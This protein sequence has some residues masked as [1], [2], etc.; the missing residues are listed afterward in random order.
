MLNDR[1]ALITGGASGLGLAVAKR[2]LAAGASVGI[3]DRSA[4][5]LE[6]ARAELG[7]RVVTTHGDVTSYDDNRRAVG[8][9]V[10]AFG[11]LDVFVG[12]AGIFDNYATLDEIPAEKLGAAF[13]ELFGIDVKGYILGAKA[14][15]AE[16]RKNKGAIVFTASIS[17]FRPGYGGLLYITAKHA[18]L[19][20]TRR[21]ALELAPDV[22]V[23][24]VAPGYVPTNLA[25]TS[26]LGQTPKAPGTKP[27]LARFPLGFYPEIDDFT[28]LYLMLASDESRIVTG[29]ALLADVGSSLMRG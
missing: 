11:K 29:Q 2:F 24:A 14:A 12:N 27:P 19:G 1:V 20:L 28:G 26:T 15:L 17:S 18:V 21:L 8:D 4:D 6:R 13:D 5:G 10:A 23:N 16:L 25:G 3:L 9:V 22:R 7:D